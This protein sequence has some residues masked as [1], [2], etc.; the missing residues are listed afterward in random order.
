VACVTLWRLDVFS[1]EIRCREATAPSIIRVVVIFPSTTAP[2]EPAETRVRPARPRSRARV[3]A[4]VCGGAVVAAAGALAV[5]VS[6]DDGGQRSMPPAVAE[7]IAASPREVRAPAA[8]TG[9]LASGPPGNAPP[10]T[11]DEGKPALLAVLAEDLPAEADGGAGGASASAEGRRA[12]AGSASTRGAGGEGARPAPKV[13]EA[14]GP[15]RSVAR[16]AAGPDAGVASTGAVMAVGRFQPAGD[17]GITDRGRDMVRVARFLTTGGATLNGHVLDAETGRPA[18]GVPVEVHL[19]RQYML[20]S[21]DQAGQ[22]AIPGM[23]PGSRV[24]VW[25]GGRDVYVEERIEVEIPDDERGAEAGT[26]RLLRGDEL[27]E[28][29]D[30]WV[31]LFLARRGGRV[32]ITAVTPWSPADRAGLAVGDAVLAVNGRDLSALGPR[33]VSFLLRGPSGSTVTLRTNG[34]HGNAQEVALQRV[35]R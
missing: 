17:R 19:D 3:L 32:V 26:I 16:A 20:T 10:S 28:R 35:P 14:A 1:V 15:S 5:V 8:R 4:F 7:T 29:L 2:A 21:A 33:A 11:G 6:D 24:V 30:G 22:F 25:V 12:A 13:A 9:E 31:G 34:A 18:A 23:V 27:G